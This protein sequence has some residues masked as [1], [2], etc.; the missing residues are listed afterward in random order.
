MGWKRL[1]V[2]FRYTASGT[3]DDSFGKKGIA[4]INLGGLDG[5]SSAEAELLGALYK[6]KAGIHQSV[7][8]PLNYWNSINGIMDMQDEKIKSLT[9]ALKNK[10]SMRIW[11]KDNPKPKPKSNAKTKLNGQ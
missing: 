11:V 1:A 7:R 6:N 10:I 4:E 2:V 5:I 8:L 3:L 9:K